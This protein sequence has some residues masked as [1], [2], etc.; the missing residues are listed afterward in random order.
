MSVLVQISGEMGPF[1]KPPV[2]MCLENTRRHLIWELPG[3][4]PIFDVLMLIYHY[5]D[6][7]GEILLRLIFC[8]TYV[9]IK[10]Y[11]PGE[12]VHIHI[13]PLINI[14]QEYNWVTSSKKG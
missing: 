14:I 2:K 10:K 6:T 8:I 11:Y 1:R 4:Y 9:I 7:I 12:P 5:I 13:Q 3:N